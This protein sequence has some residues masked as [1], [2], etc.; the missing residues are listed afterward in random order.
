MKRYTGKPHAMF[1]QQWNGSHDSDLVTA[2]DKSGW[3]TFIQTPVPGQMVN[4]YSEAE[5]KWTPAPAKDRLIIVGPYRKQLYSL[6]AGQ[7]LTW[8]EGDCSFGSQDSAP[9]ERDWDLDDDQP[10]RTWPTPVELMALADMEET[11][12]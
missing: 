8:Y 1:N 3:T 9:G 5:S 4:T 10:S 2:L 6:D 7:H 12:W 11:G